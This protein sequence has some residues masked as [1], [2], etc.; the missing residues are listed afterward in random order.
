MTNYWDP[1]F[2]LGDITS[3]KHGFY[4]KQVGRRRR[5]QAR[6]RWWVRRWE[7]RWASPSLFQ[8]RWNCYCSRWDQLGWLARSILVKEHRLACSG[9]HAILRHCLIA[10]LNNNALHSRLCLSVDGRD[11]SPFLFG[12]MMM[13]WLLCTNIW[14]SSGGCLGNVHQNH[15]V[16]Q[17]H[18]NHQFTWSS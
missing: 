13:D 2:F 14:V 8:E 10:D 12:I 3:C 17:I 9:L 11:I 18:Q 15:H 5:P 16:H 6:R 4:P 7:G 1:H